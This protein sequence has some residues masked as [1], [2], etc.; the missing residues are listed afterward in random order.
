MVFE[1]AGITCWSSTYGYKLTDLKTENIN[2][3]MVKS[4]GFLKFHQ[5]DYRTSE[6]IWSPPMAWAHKC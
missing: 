3:S 2:P 5:E 6:N 1:D 4:S